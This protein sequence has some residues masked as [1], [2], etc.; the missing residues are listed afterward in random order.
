MKGESLNNLKTL[1]EKFDETNI[2]NKE[3]KNK[4]QSSVVNGIVQRYKKTSCWA[5]PNFAKLPIH[6][7]NSKSSSTLFSMA[8]NEEEKKNHSSLNVN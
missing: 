8:Y 3:N 5:S 6:E 4:D 1:W 7:D 2:D